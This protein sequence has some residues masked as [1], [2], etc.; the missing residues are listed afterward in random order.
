MIDA[1]K[2]IRRKY[3]VQN[4]KTVIDDLSTPRFTW[5]GILELLDEFQN[6]FKSN[7]QVEMRFVNFKNNT[8]VLL[9]NIKFATYEYVKSH[10]RWYLKFGND[11]LKIKNAFA[12]F[13]EEDECKQFIQNEANRFLRKIIKYGE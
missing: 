5:N 12:S 1:E 7:M 6:D 9:D 2:F 4:N 3:Q 8:V 13:A 11:P 10:K